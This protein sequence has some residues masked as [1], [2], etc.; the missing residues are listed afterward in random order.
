M[1]E[2][3]EKARADIRQALKDYGK[4]SS[5]TSVMDDV[6]DE[7]VDRL[8]KDSSYAKQELCEMLR[9]SPAWNED[10]D[11]LVINGTRT[12]DPDYDR[13]RELAL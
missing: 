5:M 7:F 10:L 12:H 2:K 9:K 1:Q 11:A 4:Y 13:V 3:I 6:S 8:A